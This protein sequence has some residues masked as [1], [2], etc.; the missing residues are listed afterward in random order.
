MPDYSDDSDEE[1][2]A[3]IFSTSRTA[4]LLREEAAARNNELTMNND[5]DNNNNI[6]RSKRKSPHEV[7]NTSVSPEPKQRTK[8]ERKK[9]TCSHEGCS[10]RYRKVDFV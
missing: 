2:G 9:Y 10:N 3:Y 4:Q 1:L 5:N 6:T 7:K 8:N